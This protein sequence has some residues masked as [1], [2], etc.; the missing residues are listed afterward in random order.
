MVIVILLI[1]AVLSVSATQAVMR[2]AREAACLGNLRNYG[3][4]VAVF[5]ADN[6]GLP[7]WNGLK[8]DQQ[9]NGSTYPNFEVWIRPYLHGKK[10]S[11]LRCPNMNASKIPDKYKDF[12]FNYAGN[13][14][15]CIFYPKLLGFPVQ[16]SRVVLAAECFDSGLF[17]DIAHINMT[18]WGA[19]EAIANGASITNNA[20]PPQ[21]H[22]SE[23]KMS[24]NLFMLDGH[25]EQVFPVANDWKKPPIYGNMTN[26][27]YFYCQQQFMKFK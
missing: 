24:L 8:P 10:S 26:D 7:W 15:L 6:G 4:A 2:N 1:L 12:C 14:A 20:Q 3:N 22:G 27:G 13:G 16:A 19:T 11:R 9:S 21:Y 18:M 25:V 23:A 17:W 5:S